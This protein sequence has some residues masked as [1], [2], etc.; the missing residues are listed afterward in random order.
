MTYLGLPLD[1][2]GKV[3]GE[4][5]NR[6]RSL[7]SLSHLAGRFLSTIPPLATAGYDQGEQKL[8]MRDDQLD[9]RATK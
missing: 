7:N 4:L 3:G 5:L 8:V 1:L 6:I 9:C 2:F